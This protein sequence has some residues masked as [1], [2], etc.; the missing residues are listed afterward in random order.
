[1]SALAR[2]NEFNSFPLTFLFSLHKSDG[3]SKEFVGLDRS[4]AS[5]CQAEPGFTFF[6]YSCAKCFFFFGCLLRIWGCQLIYVVATERQLIGPPQPALSQCPS[7][8]SI[9]ERLCEGFRFRSQWQL[10]QLQSVLPDILDRKSA[11]L[12]ENA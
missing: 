9:E 7:L 5:K 10:L 2:K 12:V 8:P 6:R 1:M 11:K 4:W 3:P